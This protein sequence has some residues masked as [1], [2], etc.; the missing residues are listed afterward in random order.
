MSRLQFMGLCLIVLGAIPGLGCDSDLTPVSQEESRSIAREYVLASP[1]FRFD[2]MEQT[3]EL[4]SEETLR[5]PYCWEFVFEFDCR[6]AGY[7][8]RTGQ[9]LA[10]VITP[11][12]ARVVVDQGNVA[13]A[14]LDGKWDMIDQELI[15]D[16]AE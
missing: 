6:H 15:S 11:H 12:T 4:V 1:T 10:Q 7:G 2:G 13:S 14:V 16:N 9:V 3:L 5:C 8:D